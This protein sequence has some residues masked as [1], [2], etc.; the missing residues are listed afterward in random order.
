MADEGLDI[1]IPAY[2]AAN[3]IKIKLF[4][5]N[6]TPVRGDG[7]AQYTEAVG[8][9]YALKTLTANTHSVD[10]GAT[11]HDISWTP[12]TFTFTGPLT[13]N[14]TVYGYFITNSAGTK[15]LWAQLLD[16]P[17]TPINNGD[18]LP[19][20]PCKLQYSGGTPT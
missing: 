7:V 9:G 3:D 19:I 2:V 1:M 18:N 8:G 15:L 16:A 10:T 11:P 13:T 14:G 6:H 20:N 5:N 12:Q 4:C 17:F